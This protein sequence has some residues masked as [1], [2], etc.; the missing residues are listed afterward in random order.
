VLRLVDQLGFDGVD[1]GGLDESRR[2][3]AFLDMLGVFAEFETNL[4]RE[5]QMEGSAAAKAQLGAIQCLLSS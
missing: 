1:A 5:Q 4:R 3:K 2:R